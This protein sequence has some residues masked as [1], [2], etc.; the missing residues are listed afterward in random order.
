MEPNTE[1]RST[2]A[3]TAD[4]AT[5][6]IEDVLTVE[7]P[8]APAWSGDGRFVAA[9]LHADDTRLLVADTETVNTHR[10]ASGDAV[11]EFAWAPDARPTLLALTTDAGTTYGYDAADRTLT[12]WS[13]TVD[14]ETDLTWSPDGDRLASYRDGVP[15]VRN[16]E[17]GETIAFDGPERGPYFADDRMFAW[18]DDRLAYRFADRETKQVGVVDVDTGDLVW[19]TTD[20]ASTHS[21][22]WLTDGRLVFVR[23]ADGRTR[24]AFVAVDVDDGTETTLF[25]E[26][27]AERG[28]VDRGAPTISPDGTTL[29]AA[30]ALDGWAHVHAIDV[31]T[32]DRTQLTEGEFEDRG[33]AGAVPQWVDDE[34]LLFASNRRESGQR[35][36]YTVT[37]DGDVS[38]VIESAGTNVYPQPSP[39]GDRVAYVHADR[40]LSPELRVSSLTGDGSTTRLTESVVSGWPDDPLEPE[41][42]TFEGDDGREIHAFRLDPRDADEASEPL[43]AVVW[44]HG[45]PMRQMRDGWHPYRSYGLAYA[46]HQ[47]LARQGYVGLFVNYRGGIGYGREF[48]AS[49]ADGYGRDEMADVAA[50]AAYLK[51]LPHVDSDAVGI[52]GL[53]YGGYATLQLL[54]THPKAFAVGVNIAGLADIRRYEEWAW[55]TK[56]PQAE[57]LAPLRLGGSP[58]DGSARWDDASPRT[59]MDA[60]EA[61][62][63]N[64]HG[65]GDSYVN[66]DQQDIVVDRLLDLDKAFEAEYYPDE[67]HVFSKRAWRRTLEKIERAFDRHLS[68]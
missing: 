26:T 11:A 33:V 35:Q 47:Y 3:G 41:P 48:R 13:R 6:T 38:S 25:A 61:P 7:Y 66:V 12:T 49:L 22:A 67:G 21:P 2:E 63:Y 10:I 29:A 45:G 55:K 60:Y 50:G 44:I 58:W 31:A 42:V 30:L 19:R 53:S 54:G 8:G 62:V 40:K 5:L 46:F 56:F 34:T 32:G 4:P 52:W 20:T 57:S 28:I 64:F 17:T 14:G 15:C 16:V 24:R 23:L 37:L 51:D 18:N 68:G 59:H 39:D 27:D 36:L 9:T 43:P 65:T 1:A